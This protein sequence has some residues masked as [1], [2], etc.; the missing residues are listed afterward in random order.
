MKR[1]N[2]IL[3]AGLSVASLLLAGCGEPAQTLSSGRIS[4][5]KPWDGAGAGDPYAADGWKAGDEQAWRAQ[6]RSRML[7]QNEYTR[8]GGR[9]P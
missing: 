7:N 5:A 2:L 8:T 4:D 6:M 1:L 3:A 9:A